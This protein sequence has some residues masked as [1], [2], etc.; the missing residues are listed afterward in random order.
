MAK[1]VKKSSG[2]LKRAK[3]DSHLADEVGKVIALHKVGINWFGKCVYCEDTGSHFL[4][5]HHGK[6]WQCLR[7]NKKGVGVP[8]LPAN[9]NQG[10]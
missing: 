2:G 8:V 5:P 3:T 9:N 7:C 10:F 6:Y 4:V 1:S